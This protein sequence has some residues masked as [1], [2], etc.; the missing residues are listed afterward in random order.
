LDTQIPPYWNKPEEEKIKIF[1]N[2]EPYL[3]Y[4]DM[5]SL[6]AKGADMKSKLEQNDKQLTAT[7][8]QLGVLFQIMAIEDPQERQK[9]LADEAKR[10][11]EKGLYSAKE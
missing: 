2:V 4:L 7:R 6:E 9:K 11:V 10:W 3:T 8:E 5:V 1:G